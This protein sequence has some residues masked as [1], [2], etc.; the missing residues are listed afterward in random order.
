[1]WTIIVI[2]LIIWLAV[3]VL[4]FVIEGLFW[5]AVFGIILF[6]ATAIVGW[7]RGRVN[8]S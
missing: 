6:I 5:L 1:M 7:V 8:K 4:G 3:S 2:L